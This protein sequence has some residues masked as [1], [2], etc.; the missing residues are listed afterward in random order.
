MANPRLVAW[1]RQQRAGLPDDA[2]FADMLRRFA[3][4]FVY[5]T[6]ITNP[7]DAA[8]DDFFFD[9]QRLLQLFRHRDGNAL[10]AAGIEANV[11][12]GY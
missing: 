6:R 7:T 11:V 1:A 10:R 9:N 5:D 8:L 4:D 3:S 2:T 12:M